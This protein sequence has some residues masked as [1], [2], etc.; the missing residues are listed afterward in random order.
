[1]PRKLRNASARMIAGIV[2]VK[3]TN[4]WLSVFGYRCRKMMRLSDAPISL[5][6]RT[7]SLARKESTLPRT[8]RSS[9]V[10][11]SRAKMNDMITKMLNE[12]QVRGM[13]AANAIQSGNCGKQLTNSTKRWIDVIGASAVVARRDAEHRADRHADQRAEHRHRQ[14]DAPGLARFPIQ[15]AA[16][17]VRPQQMDQPAFFNAE[18]VAVGGDQ[19][20]GSCTPTPRRRSRC[21]RSCRCSPP[22][23]ARRFSY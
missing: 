5:A 13:M 4:T 9:V 20:P 14:R 6:A 22:R 17:L 8:S 3:M 2:R 1:M 18:E 16:E 21:Q 23:S 7:K 10:Q 15:V 11:E 19:C 12:S